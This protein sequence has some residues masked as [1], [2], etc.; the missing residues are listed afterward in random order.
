MV[1][2]PPTEYKRMVFS[3]AM[4]NVLVL[5]LWVEHKLEI[6]IEHVE[7]DADALD[8]LK[9]LWERSKVVG[10]ELGKAVRIIGNTYANRD[11]VCP[12][13]LGSTRRFCQTCAFLW[14]SYS[15][16]RHFETDFGH[17]E[18]CF[19]GDKMAHLRRDDDEK[20]EG[21]EDKLA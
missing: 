20:E 4:L 14:C 3:Q 5:K 9:K 15:D 12:D 11:H 19:A 7:S 16:P 10:D 1:V 6:N 21:K 13:E 2:S 18:S 17:C 8:V